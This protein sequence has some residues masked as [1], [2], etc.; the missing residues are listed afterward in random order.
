M[1]GLFEK[2]GILFMLFWDGWHI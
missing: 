2:H 1:V